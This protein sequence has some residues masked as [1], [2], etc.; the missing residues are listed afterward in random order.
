MKTKIIHYF[1][2]AETL[3]TE[4]VVWISMVGIVSLLSVGVGI[5][6]YL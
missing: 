2:E 1:F 3:D 6:T 4:T 5:S